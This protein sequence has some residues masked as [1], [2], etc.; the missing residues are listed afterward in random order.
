[1]SRSTKTQAV[2]EHFCA[3][4]CTTFG[5]DRQQD[6][7]VA[8]LTLLADGGDPGASFWLRADP[9]HVQPTQNDLLL[10]DSGS[11]SQQEAAELIHSLNVYFAQEGLGWRAPHPRRWYLTGAASP[12]IATTPAS[13]AFGR[14][15]DALLPRGPDALQWHRRFNEAQMLLHEHPVNQRRESRGEPAINSVWFWGGGMLPAPAYSHG[16]AVWADD[17]LL[18]GLAL[19]SGLEP[20][21][22]PS[23]AGAWLTQASA[24]D[25]LILLDALAPPVHSGDAS[26]W[27]VQV[28]VL[29]RNW[30]RPLLEFL[31]RRAIARLTITTQHSDL[32]LYYEVLPSDLWKFWRRDAGVPR[33]APVDA[34]HA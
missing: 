15:V 12:D 29:E 7:P 5:V 8:P 30:F 33:R 25:N 32:A 2:A 24:G 28:D 16:G 27:A 18:R 3:L 22:L 34:V 4:L 1:M 6:W 11:V 9:V 26:E 10:A 31:A 20:K 21:P 13:H 23:N 19:S 17:P 14:S